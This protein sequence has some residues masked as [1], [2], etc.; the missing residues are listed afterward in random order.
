VVLQ[1]SAGKA[2]FHL[3]AN[4]HRVEAIVEALQEI[5]GLEI[6]ALEHDDAEPR[7]MTK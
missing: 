7:A 4:R 3:D 5:E 2:F 6:Q 1:L